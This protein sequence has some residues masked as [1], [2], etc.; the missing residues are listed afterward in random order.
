M[1]WVNEAHKLHDVESVNKHLARIKG[2]QLLEGKANMTKG[3]FTL[4]LARFFMNVCNGDR[5]R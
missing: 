3:Y 4:V 2:Q 5:R 1:Y